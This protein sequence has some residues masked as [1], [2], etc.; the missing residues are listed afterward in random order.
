MSNE[1]ALLI[2]SEIRRLVD[3]GH[4]R[5]TEVITKNIEQLHKVAGAL[6]EYETLTGDEIKTL[7]EKGE[8]NRD[9]AALRPAPVPTAGT[10]IPKTGRRKSVKSG[11]EVQDA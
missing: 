2:D 7:V 4:A 10:S 5:A 8:L 9:D 1:T 6:L 11:V 3:D